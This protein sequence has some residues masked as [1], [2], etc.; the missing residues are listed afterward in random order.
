MGITRKSTDPTNVEIDI[1]NPDLSKIGNLDTLVITV[2]LGINGYIFGISKSDLEQMIYVN[3]Q[4]P[5]LIAREAIHITK[6]IVFTA[7]I[8]GVRPREGNSIYAGSK[9]GLIAMV[10]SMRK[11]LPDHILQT[12]SFDNISVIGEN[13]IMNTYKFLIDNKCNTDVHISR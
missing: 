7:S 11:E 2:G 10:D 5:A 6:H 8:A 12:I 4:L 9:A 3:L 1:N 13:K